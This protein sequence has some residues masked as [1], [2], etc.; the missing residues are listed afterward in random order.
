MR[1]A[2]SSLKRFEK[3]VEVVKDAN[4][5]SKSL[6]SLDVRTRWNSAYLMLEATEKFERAFDRLIIDDE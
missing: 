6:L 5:Q 1:Y 4:I 3:F 2:K